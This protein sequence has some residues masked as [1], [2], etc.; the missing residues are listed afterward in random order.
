MSKINNLL[1]PMI[2]G[3]TACGKT[4]L[5]IELSK[6][7]N[8]E[9]VSADSR[10]VYKYMDIGTAKPSITQRD[11]CKHH[12]IDIVEPNE[13][14]SAGRFAEDA[15]AVIKN[16]ID[17]GNLP[18]VVGGSGLYIKALTDG[19]FDAPDVSAELRKGISAELESVGSVVMH[20]KL[21]KIDPESADRINPNDWKKICRALELNKVSGLTVSMLH[22]RN[23][24]KPL[25]KFFTIY[26]DVPREKLYK[27]IN[28]RVDIMVRNGLFE[29]VEYLVKTKGYDL[30]LNSMKTVGYKEV[31][32]YLDG[33][34][35]KER[36]IELIKQNTRRYAKRQITWFKKVAID[37]VFYNGND[38]NKIIQN[39]K[40]VSDIP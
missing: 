24:T 17:G 5:A 22:K 31:I 16:I 15:N 37:M 30:N 9:I 33:L 12:L 18:V 29:E 14:Y 35:S 2:C 11:M 28:N 38:I 34:Q 1:V 27:I 36:A 4:N 20:E 13:L 40:K 19:L 25:W 8:V 10:Q 23:S 26:I 32:E 7:L 3:P 21:K 6:K 39:Y